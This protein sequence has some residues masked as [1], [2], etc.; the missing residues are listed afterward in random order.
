MSSFHLSINNWD[1]FRY[2]SSSMDS[3]PQFLFAD[4]WIR[5]SLT[6]VFQ[7]IFF[8]QYKYFFL[9]NNILSSSVYLDPDPRVLMFKLCRPLS[10]ILIAIVTHFPLDNTFLYPAIYIPI[11]CLIASRPDG[12]Q[13]RFG[14]G[15]TIRTYCRIW[16]R[17]KFRW[18]SVRV[19]STVC[20]YF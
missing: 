1:L 8:P 3:D 7:M 16:I 17:W 12:G 14:S 13:R 4:L 5:I 18:N 6:L 19:T 11:F 10:E 2:L 9:S 20:P 15:P